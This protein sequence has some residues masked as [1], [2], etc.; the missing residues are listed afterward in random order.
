[1][2]FKKTTIMFKLMQY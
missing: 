1:M 2:G